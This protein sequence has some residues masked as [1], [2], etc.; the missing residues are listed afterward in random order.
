MWDASHDD[1]AITNNQQV[2]SCRIALEPSPLQQNQVNRIADLNPY[3]V[4]NVEVLRAGRP[5]R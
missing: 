5:R 3:D 2:V 1:V 4:D